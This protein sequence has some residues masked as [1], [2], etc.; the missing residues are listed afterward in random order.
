MEKVMPSFE[1]EPL[2][3]APK[4]Q[5]LNEKKDRRDTNGPGPLGIGIPQELGDLKGKK[6]SL[7]KEDVEQTL[8]Q[9]KNIYK[10]LVIKITHLQLQKQGVDT[11]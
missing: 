10:K 8:K 5:T 2:V 9:V 11:S 1:C 3:L 4:P 7:E 6:D